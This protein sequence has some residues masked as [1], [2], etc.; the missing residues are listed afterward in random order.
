MQKNVA[1]EG[2][3]KSWIVSR[4]L[5]PKGAVVTRMSFYIGG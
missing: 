2:G 4:E 1:L 5:R 3:K